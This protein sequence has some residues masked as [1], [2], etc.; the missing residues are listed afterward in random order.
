M[1]NAQQAKTLRCQGLQ[2]R[3]CIPKIVKRG[4]RRTNLKSISPKA[5]SLGIYGIINNEARWFEAWG[6]WRKVIGKRWGN[7]FS[8]KA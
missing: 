2:Q 4:D 8:A 5:R 1:P 7:R 3:W 6:T